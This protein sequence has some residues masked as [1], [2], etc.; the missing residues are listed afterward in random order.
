MIGVHGAAILVNMMVVIQRFV[1]DA[2]RGRVFGVS[3]MVTMGALAGAT[4]LLGLPNIPHLDRY[5]PYLLGIVALGLA[6]TFVVAWREYRRGDELWWVDWLLWRLV[7]TYARFWGRCER[8]GPCTIPVKGPVI[9]ASNHT[10]GIDPMAI[11]AESPHRLVSFIVEAK[12]YSVQPAKWFMDRAHCIAIDRE[13][14]QKS[15][16]SKSMRHLKEGGL[17]GIFPEG[18]YPEPGEPLPE[19]KPGVG[20]LA[21]RTDATVIPCHISGARYAYNPFVAYFQRHNL[22]IRFGPPVDLTEL[23]QRAR[24]KDAPQEAADL[25]MAKIRALAPQGS[26]DDA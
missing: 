19:V 2:R 9:L 13:N 15:F 21:L 25:I 23:R 12:Y 1:P 7:R 18:T 3:D 4:G 16:F 11:L 10:S 20:L 5:I 17:L 14:P 8:I 24:D 6:I 22:R 26:D